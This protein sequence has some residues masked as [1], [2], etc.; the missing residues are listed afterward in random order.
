MNYQCP[1][2]GYGALTQPPER[3]SICPCCGTEFE[4]DDCMT[5]HEEL[6]R[7]WLRAGAPWFSRATPPPDGW[8]PSEQLLAAGYGDS[9]TNLESSEREVAPH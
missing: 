9:L 8:N 5:S 1:V 7:Q 2:C 3:Y 4:L 6:R